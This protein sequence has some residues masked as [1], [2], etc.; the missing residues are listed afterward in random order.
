MRPPAIGFLVNPVAGM[1]GAVG[2]KGTDGLYAEALRRGA[3]PVT[4][5]RAALFLEALRLPGIRILTCSGPMGADAAAAAGISGVQIV[6][7]VPPETDA[8]HTA[9]ACRAMRAAGASVIV[10]CGGDGTA[11]DVFDAVG[12]S[13]LILGIPA[14]VK[15][16]SAVFAA[17]PA[18][19]AETIR[20]WNDTHAVDA[21]VVDVDEAA[22]RD[23]DLRI[24]VYGIARVPSLPGIR[25]AGKQ[26]TAGRSEEEAQEEI[27]RFIAEIVRDDTLYLIGAG[28]TTR[29]IARRLGVEPTLLGV[30]ALHAGRLVGSDLDEQ[31]ILRLCDIYPRIRII[32]S[33][34]GAQGFV[35]G[36]GNQQISAAVLARAGPE[37]LIVVATPGKL[38]AT[39]RL[40]ADVGDPALEA[41]LGRSLLV[42]SGYRMAERKPLCTGAALFEAGDE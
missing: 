29:A 22:Y 4:P 1:G 9:D 30:D 8:A 38:A 26:V 23:G 19:A 5:R 32:I 31:G 2:L 21:E 7:A 42:V 16:Y 40:C 14:G 39:P 41:S 25:H 11:R 35:L 17:S 37:S 33:P 12:R 28:T 34:I 27:A 20:R 3:L 13:S 10:F 18:H 6:H 15:M 24:R 36:R